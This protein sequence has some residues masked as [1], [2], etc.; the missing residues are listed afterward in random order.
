LCVRET[1]N[2]QKRGW[3]VSESES[4]S[5]PI[6]IA[7]SLGR[8]FEAPVHEAVKCK[9]IVASEAAGKYVVE[10]LAAFVKPD[11]VAGSAL[12]QPITFLLRDAMEARGTERFKRFQ[13]LGDGVL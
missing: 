9:R 6:E 13:S 3:A 7:A 4:G 1:K 11:E 5:S 12:S 8:Y 2:A 10:L